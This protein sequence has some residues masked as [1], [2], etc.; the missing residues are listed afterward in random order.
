MK[1]STAYQTH[2]K[3]TPHSHYPPNK[4][5][6]T[7]NTQIS[8]WLRLYQ[9]GVTSTY[10]LDHGNFTFRSDIRHAYQWQISIRTRSNHAFFTHSTT[11]CCFNNAQFSPISS[12]YYANV[13]RIKRFDRGQIINV[14]RKTTFRSRSDHAH[15]LLR[16][17]LHHITVTLL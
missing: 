3:L 10:S 9:T 14:R 6:I 1:L 4:A 17:R 16:W 11:E 2:I 15:I 5:N 12:L 7:E 13:T 8:L